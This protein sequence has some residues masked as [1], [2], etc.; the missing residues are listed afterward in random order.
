MHFH[1][2]F[3][4]A[5]FGQPLTVRFTVSN[6]T[7]AVQFLEHV[8]LNASLRIEYWQSYT[9]DDYISFIKY[10]ATDESSVIRWLQHPHPRR[11]DIMIELI[12]PQGT[13][14][15]L[16][17]YRKYD[18]VNS[19]DEGY[20]YHLWPF[21]S[22]HYWGENPVGTWTVIVTFKSSSGYVSVSDVELA[23]YGTSSTPQAVANIPQVCDEACARGCYENGPN[24]CDVCKDFRIVST[25]ECVTTCPSNTSVYR[26]SYCT[27]KISNS[28]VATAVGTSMG[29]VGLLALIVCIAVACIVA[30]MCRKKKNER[31]SR[32]YQVVRS[33]DNTSSVP[34]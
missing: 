3:R 14:S 10:E 5:R 25:L 26:G 4:S 33:E 8:V 24:A 31:A 28:I 11:G 6:M 32:L 34:V 13:T 19:D 15:T 27:D 9:I 12:S 18:F 20:A 22:V 7:S 21:M 2:H 16:L 1:M 17:P 23:L 29:L 30:Y